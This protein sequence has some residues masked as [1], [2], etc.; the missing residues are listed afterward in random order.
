MIITAGRSAQAYLAKQS[1][2]VS[3]H[4]RDQAAN[5]CVPGEIDSRQPKNKTHRGQPRE[6]ANP[7]LIFTRSTEKQTQ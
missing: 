4:H 6:Q 1:H 2:S 5:Q 3:H 7:G